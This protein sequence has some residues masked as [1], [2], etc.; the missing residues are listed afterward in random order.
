MPLTAPPTETWHEIALARR[1]RPAGGPA[2]GDAGAVPLG[3]Q[4]AHRLRRKHPSPDGRYLA[5]AY[6]HTASDFWTGKARAWTELATGPGIAY[7]LTSGPIPGPDFGAPWPAVIFWERPQAVRFVF[8]GLV[9]RIET[10]EYPPE[11]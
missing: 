11:P 2:A 3:G 7:H 6:D 5:T 10:G 9:L 1:R 4:P 8:P